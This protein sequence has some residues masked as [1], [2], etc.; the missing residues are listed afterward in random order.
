MFFNII[1]IFIII[2]FIILFLLNNNLN[3]HMNK[4]NSYE[5]FERIGNPLYGT[6]PEEE[7]HGCQTKCIHK[8]KNLLCGN[9]GDIC[10]I[11]QNNISTCCKGYSCK[12]KPGN[13]NYKVCIK[14]G[15]G[16]NEFGFGL[17]KYGSCLKS[18]IDYPNAN[19]NTDSISNCN[20][21]INFNNGFLNNNFL[22]S[23]VFN[24]SVCPVK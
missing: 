8:N 23:P 22:K 20:S 13:F 4:H 9:N 14:D 16:N 19:Y 21:D 11:N 6:I 7:Y 10:S 3:K 17:L 24:S 5:Y 12:R 1:I 18:N 15:L 2:L